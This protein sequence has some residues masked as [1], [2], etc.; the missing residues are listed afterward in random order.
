MDFL[1]SRAKHNKILFFLY[2]NSIHLSL[3][4]HK[5]FSAALT[6]CFKDL[7][8]S[9]ISLWRV[10]L[11]IWFQF[12]QIKAKSIFSASE[13]WEVT[14]FVVIIYDIRVMIHWFLAMFFHIIY[15][16]LKR[17]PDAFVSIRFIFAIFLFKFLF[18]FYPWFGELFNLTFWNNLFKVHVFARLDLIAK[19][20]KIFLKAI[21]FWHYNTIPVLW[22]DHY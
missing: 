11:N 18:P 14:F 8:S 19:S 22:T 5:L 2:S 20:W 10:R 3:G 4:S 1:L 15:V 17:V 6:V 12:S 7:R 16:L 21:C 9:S 13:S